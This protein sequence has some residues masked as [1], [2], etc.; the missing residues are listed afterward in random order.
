[1]E[2]ACRIPSEVVVRE[3]PKRLAKKPTE[4]FPSEY[5]ILLTALLLS[6]VCG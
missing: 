4:A 5:Q 1:M 3:T 6:V 2:A